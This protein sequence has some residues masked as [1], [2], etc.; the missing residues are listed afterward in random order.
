VVAVHRP[1]VVPYYSHTVSVDL[2]GQTDGAMAAVAPSDPAGTD[3]PFR[4]DVL[5]ALDSDPVA[6]L[7][8]SYLL[9]DSPQRILQPSWFPP[10]VDARYMQHAIQVKKTWRVSQRDRVWVNIYIRRDLPMLRPEI[11]VEQGN[12]FP[13]PDPFGLDCVPSADGANGAGCG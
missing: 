10:A 6:F 2:T 12:R 13:D 11:S 1:G 9:H 7:P 4:F 8:P 3:H 5:H